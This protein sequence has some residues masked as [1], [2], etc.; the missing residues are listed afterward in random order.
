MK[1]H[2]KRTTIYLDSDLHHALRV[3]AA[4]TEHSISELVQEAVELSLTEDAADLKAF[5]N[6][7]NEPSLAF[8]NVLK[9][10]RKNGKI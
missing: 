1:L 5:E 7:K 6:R 3:K 8:E 2:T 10:L 4:E 9:K